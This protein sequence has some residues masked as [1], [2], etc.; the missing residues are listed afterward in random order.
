MFRLF[1]LFLTM[2]L[3]WA[4]YGVLSLLTR[5]NRKERD[6]LFAMGV[7]ICF[8]VHILD[9]LIK[10]T[11]NLNYFHFISTNIYLLAG[12]SLW[13]YTQSLLKK[14]QLNWKIILMHFIPFVIWLVITI[15]N[16]D[17]MLQFYTR[18]P[19]R[20]PHLPKSP[21][22]PPPGQSH[23]P[24]LLKVLS[25]Y[26]SIIVYVCFIQIKL[27]KHSKTVKEFYSYKTFSNTLSWLRYL[28]LIIIPAYIY[29]TVNEILKFNGIIALK[30]NP[31]SLL[32]IF[33]VIYI[34]FFSF[35]SRDQH[36][37][38]DTKS[39][40]EKDKYKKSNIDNLEL[41]RIYKKLLELMEEK[42][43]YLDPD[44]NL[45][46]LASELS[47][48]KHNLSQVLNMKAEKNFYTFI[49]SYRIEIFKEVIKN[50]T[51]PN[52]SLL[53]IAMECGFRSSS[54]FYSIFKKMVGT[55]PKLYIKTIA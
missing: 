21:V 37:P 6:T 7:L 23:Y 4:I 9:H 20:L 45:D 32:T 46:D 47:I 44:I 40:L 5:K 24:R 18:I 30:S 48:S 25:S 26:I 43:L 15:I 50:N 8:T 41:D 10:P 38:E 42:K 16:N 39:E 14:E 17:E 28:T 22:M 27:Y 13:L 19:H 54:A 51:Y 31:V 36:I 49:N 29:L 34:F 53:A 33:P 1:D 35:F 3:A 55:T 52:Y 11:N 12:P 2:G